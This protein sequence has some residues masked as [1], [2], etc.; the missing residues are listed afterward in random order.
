M[1]AYA[2]RR[3]AM[4]A[5]VVLVLLTL[6]AALVHVL[7]GDPVTLMLGPQA[8]GD[9]SR[10]ARTEMD[11]DSPVHLQVWHFIAGAAQGDLGRDFLTRVPVASLIAQAL[12]HTL[13]L[14]VS[15]LVL[16]VAVAIPLG[17]VSAARPGSLLDR[18]VGTVSVGVISI[19]SYV[20]G[21]SLLLV[22]AVWLGWLPALGAGALRSP[23]D[24]VAHLLLPMC[25]LALIWAGYLARIV[26][27]SMLEVLDSNYIRAARAFGVHDRRILYQLSLRNAIVPVVALLGVALGDLMGS[28]I[29]VEVIFTR[30][31]LGT[32]LYNAIAERNFPV[33]RG[34]VVVIAVLFVVANLA[35]DLA[36]RLLDPRVRADQAG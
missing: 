23:I 7:P 26:R 17:V 22:F 21:L 3:L 16:A 18:A 6:L 10:L 35:A 27:A 19:P 15:S 36:N 31:G 9:L 28:A 32:L 8:S 1:M 30:N 24:Y 20:V 13:I 29:F 4:T 2:L 5:M 25:A 11:L 34:A 14:A 12:P 33:V